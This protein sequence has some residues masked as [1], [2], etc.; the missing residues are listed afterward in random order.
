[1]D[2]DSLKIKLS[3]RQQEI[4]FLLTNHIN[5]HIAAQILQMQ[6]GSISKIIRKYICPKFH[7]PP[8]DKT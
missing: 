4:M 2:E 5:M 1:M 6:Y 7:I 8:E 3:P